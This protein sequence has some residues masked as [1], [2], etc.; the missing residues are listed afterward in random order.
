MY[1]I[2]LA[3]LEIVIFIIC[4][5][6]FIYGTC[7]KGKRV[8]AKTCFLLVM[9]SIAYAVHY[10]FLIYAFSGPEGCRAMHPSTSFIFFLPQAIFFLIFIWAI[11]KLLMVWRGMVANSEEEA[12]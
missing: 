12:D 11:F 4:F 1:M 3:S 9:F 8:D 7:K 6:L 5:I 10:V 2:M